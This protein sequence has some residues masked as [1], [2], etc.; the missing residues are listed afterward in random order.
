MKVILDV[1]PGTDDALAIMMALNSPDLT[2]SGITTVGGNATL[3]D[4]TRNTLRLLDALGKTPRLFRD[5]CS[6]IVSPG[7]SRPLRGRY[8]YGYYYH[9]STGLGIRLPSPKSKPHSV[10][11]EDFIIEQASSDQ[12]RLTIIALGPL[13][14]IAH[15]LRKNPHLGSQLREIVIMGGAF[16]VPGNI[17]QAAEFNVYNDPA[18]A[19]FLFSAGIPITLIPLDVCELTY[20]AQIDLPW[21]VGSSKTILLAQRIVNG[22]FKNRT[23]LER[24]Y[25]CDPLAI[26][27][28][29]QPDIFS[30]VEAD[31]KVHLSDDYL[32][33]KTTAAYGKGT[34][35]IASSL[36]V[37]IAKKIMSEMLNK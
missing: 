12:E 14:N 6:V 10:R 5:G 7:S 1:D 4:T 27:A 21:P 36:N 35:K 32:L 18:A 22:W 29:V 23:S 37:S 26:V 13:T 33:G 3:F 8:Q 28:T 9:G 20:L 19:S 34:V 30:F 17:T 25:L 31:V 24:Y 11:A 2:V 16:N 15:A